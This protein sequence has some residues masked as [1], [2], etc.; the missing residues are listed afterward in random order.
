MTRLEEQSQTRRCLRLRKVLSD[1]LSELLEHY[2]NAKQRLRPL[3]DTTNL[4][5]YYDIYDFS[6]E[7]L[8]EAESALFDNN[9]EDR[10]SLRLLRI[11][12]AKVYTARKGTL[13]CLLA[14]PADG[15]ESDIKKWNAAIE[16]MENLATR[17]GTCIQKLTDI[18]NEQDR[19]YIRAI[20][21]T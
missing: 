18:L 14:L 10:T 7:E 3:T 12:F 15:E 21:S 6:P 11:L 4:E 19:K 9:N 13:C 16:V 2:L 20:E 17:T 5:K 1:C 8:Q